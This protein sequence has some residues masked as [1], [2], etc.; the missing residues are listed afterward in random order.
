MGSDD[1][2][3]SGVAQAQKRMSSARGTALRAQWG[4]DEFLDRTGTPG[5]SDC[6]SARPA[7]HRSADAASH[8]SNHARAS[9]CISASN[10]CG[11]G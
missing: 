1:T 2:P 11:P 6:S 4:T 8:R 5:D 10:L 7:A 3:L 9:S